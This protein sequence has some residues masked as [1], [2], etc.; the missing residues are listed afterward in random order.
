MYKNIALILLLLVAVAAVPAMAASS[1]S[2]SDRNI[3]ITRI[4]VHPSGTGLN[5]TVYYNTNLFTDIFSKFFG[6]KTIQPSIE[7]TFGNFTNAT[8]TRIDLDQH[9]AD[10]TVPNETYSNGQG[11]NVYDKNEAFPGEIDKLEIRDTSA[12]PMILEN[13]DALPFFTAKP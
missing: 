6:A 7:S 10:V 5:F 1:G 12:G 11:L 13:A 3:D 9:V 4:V 8:I 2:S